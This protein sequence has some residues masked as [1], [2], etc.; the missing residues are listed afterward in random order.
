MTDRNLTQ[1]CV[2]NL[3]IGLFLVFLHAKLAG[4]IDWPW[5]YIGAP[6][7]IPFVTTFLITFFVATFTQLKKNGVL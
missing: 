4:H 2:N 1:L 5:Y 3:L 7:L 6:I